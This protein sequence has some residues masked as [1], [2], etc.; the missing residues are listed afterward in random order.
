M[1]MK[2]VQHRA[3]EEDRKHRVFEKYFLSVLCPSL[4]LCVEPLF[5]LL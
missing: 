3:T 1:I 5:S 4:W 2:G